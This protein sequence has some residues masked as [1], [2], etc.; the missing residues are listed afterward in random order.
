MMTIIS[1]NIVLLGALWQ[2]NSPYEYDR[3]LSWSLVS[4]VCH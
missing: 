2:Q 1:S 4:S 3:Y